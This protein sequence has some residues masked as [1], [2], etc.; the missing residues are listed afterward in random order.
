MNRNRRADWRRIRSHLS[1]TYEEAARVLS[2]HRMT[3]RHWVKHCG[4]PVLAEK[5][6][7]LIQGETLK[8][9]LRDRRTSRKRKCGAGEMFCLKCRAPRRPVEGLLEHR[10]YSGTRGAIVGLCPDCGTLMHRFVSARRTA[11][12]ASDF[13]V[14]IGHRDESLVDSATPSPN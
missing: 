3:V 9:F 14:Q 13:H 8:T 5:R 11:A 10:T 2:V 12:V 7:H 4:L 1:Y 6:P